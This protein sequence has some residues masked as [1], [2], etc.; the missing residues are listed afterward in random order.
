MQMI[1]F[2]KKARLVPGWL[3]RIDMVLKLCNHIL[4]Y[5]MSSQFVK[6]NTILYYYSMSKIFQ[7]PRFKN[8]T[9]SGRAANGATTLSR[10]LAQKLGWIVINGGEIYREYVKKN[11]IPLEKTTKVPDAYHKELD[12]LIKDKL[13]SKKNLI[14]ESW[15]SGFDAQKIDGVFKVFITCSSDAVRIDRLVN[16][17][18]MTI[19][20]AKKH[21][22]VREAEN[23]KK[24]TRLYH[25]N[26][27]WS[28]A[29][30][31]LVIDTFKHDRQETLD[32]VLKSIGFS[33]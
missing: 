11:G 27:F 2:I 4:W 17:E 12:A 29:L 8:I 14:I 26:N 16:R 19:D 5:H 20:E 1:F 13:V 6:P 28:P 33:K 10:L 30:Y 21:I 15:L 22:K 25:T 7:N 18:G 23:I 24:W 3:K 31:D 32:L 9:I